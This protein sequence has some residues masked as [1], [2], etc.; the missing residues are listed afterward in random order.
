MAAILSLPQCVNLVIPE[1]LSFITRKVN[2]QKIQMACILDS[3]FK[4]IF[5]QDIVFLIQIVISLSFSWGSTQ[6]LSQHW[7]G[8][9]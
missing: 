3:N 7:L 8:N 1:Y 4:G 9:G 6:E 2:T 5:L